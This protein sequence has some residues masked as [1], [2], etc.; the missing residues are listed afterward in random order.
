M[1]RADVGSDDTSQVASGLRAAISLLV[2]R[3][4]QSP[5]GDELSLPQRSALSRL[6]RGGPA[7]A[8][9]LAKLEQ[10]SPQSMG[11]TLADL[12]SRGLI[13]RQP[14]PDDGRRAVISLTASGRKTLTARRS[15][16]DELLAAALREEFTATELHQLAA[17]TRLLDRLAQRI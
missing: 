3:L 12:E 2:R 15:A 1:A 17:A 13:K 4:R 7:G 8:S 6:D 16:R 11:A 10:I 14:D 9:E 5:G